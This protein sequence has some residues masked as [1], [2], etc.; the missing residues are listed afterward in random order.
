[1]MVYQLLHMDVTFH[2]PAYALLMSIGYRRQR[3]E[4]IVFVEGL[5]LSGLGFPLAWIVSAFLC[6]LVTTNTSLPMVISIQMVAT[7]FLMILFM[8]ST[9]ALLAMGKIKDADPADLF[10]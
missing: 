1:M 4:M 10:Q 9:S 5:I 7:T 2:L 8:C 3:L 6:Y